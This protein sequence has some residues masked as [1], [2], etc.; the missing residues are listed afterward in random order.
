MLLGWGT[1]GALVV[2]AITA[3]LLARRRADYWPVAAFLCAVFLENLLRVPLLRFQ[4][5]AGT[6]LEGWPRVA[7]HVN[8]ALYLVWDAALTIAA[9]YVFVRREN[10]RWLLALPALAWAGTVAYLVTHYPESVRDVYAMTDIAA[11]TVGA[12]A[13]VAW[14]W[15][16]LS[17]TPAHVVITGVLLAQLLTVIGG[18]LRYGL[19]DKYYLD[20]TISLLTYAILSVYQVSSWR[21]RSLPH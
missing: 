9:I 3:V 12:A 8:E 5:E 1:F 14:S 19:W 16:R 13:V 6:P 2:A 11:V 17:P 20:Q 10:L 4:P 7:L 18:A 21:S 15:R